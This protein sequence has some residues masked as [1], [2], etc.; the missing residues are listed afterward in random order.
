MKSVLTEITA[1]RA[2]GTVGI[3]ALAAE[4]ELR[5]RRVENTSRAGLDIVP[6]VSG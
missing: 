1:C 5:L 6:A 3:K 2:N 4:H